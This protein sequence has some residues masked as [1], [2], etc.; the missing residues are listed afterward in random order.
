MAARE[1]WRMAGAVLHAIGRGDEIV[2]RF[3][4]RPL[5]TGLAAWLAN[6]SVPTTTSAG[7]LFDA[8]AGLLGVCEVQEYEGQAAMEL[9]ALVRAPRIHMDSWRIVD[10][11]LDLRR[12]LSHLAAHGIDRIVGAELFHGTLTAALADW[13]E[14][15]CRA[16]GIST[17]ALGGGCLLNRVLSD[18]LAATLRARG[19]VP[20]L[21]RQVPPN[22]GGLSLGQAWVAANV[23]TARDDSGPSRET[24]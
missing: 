16:T 8:V 12:L 20:L 14:Q 4:H 15:A 18:A 23:L 5:S 3:P 7:R 19:L 24:T 6:G 2:L 9:E 21:A 11:V 10:G 17:V 22:D 1:P 13:A